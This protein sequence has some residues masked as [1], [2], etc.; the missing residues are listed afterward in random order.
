MEKLDLKDRKI[1]YYLDFDSRQSF[2]SLGKKVGLSKDVVT[3][4]VKKLQEND[5]L[6]GFFAVLNY[7]KISITI[8]RFYFTFQNVT[9]EIKKEILDFFIKN[10]T[11]GA[12]KSIEGSYDLLVAIYVKSYPEAHGFW[13]NTLKK[14]GKYFSKKVF[15]AFSQEEFYTYRFLLDDKDIQPLILHKWFDS[16]NRIEIDDL[17]YK[18]LRLI[19]ENSRLS[20]LD[21]AKQL[22]TTSSVINYRLKKLNESEVILSYRL[23]LNFPKLGYF[24]FKVD[25]E[26]NQ[27]DKIDKILGY[28]KSNQNFTYLCKTI[29][30]VD[31]EIAF[32]LN[33]SYQLNQIMEDLSN[34]FPNAIKNYS[35]FSVIK[36]Y[37][38]YTI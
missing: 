15:T 33:N 32:L 6:K 12:V 35:Y 8:Y 28:I 23:N 34:K 25:I 9:P 14:Y 17:D 4:R 16:G 24:P 5:I 26:L 38:D 19:T 7:P 20:T 37:K 11:V 18:L 21:M 22:N 29:G 3:S 2:R 31:L 10:Q 13:Q 36:T 1:L 27:F 30:Y